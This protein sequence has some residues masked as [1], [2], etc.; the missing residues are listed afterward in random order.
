M[1]TKNKYRVVK[2]EEHYSY[3]S[4]AFGGAT[5]HDTRSIWQ[6]VSDQGVIFTCTNMVHPKWVRDQLNKCDDAQ[7]LVRHY[8]KEVAD[9]THQYRKIKEEIDRLKQD[10]E[11]AELL[12]EVV[13]DLAKRRGKS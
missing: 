3:T 12:L 13:K 7:L 11:H 4:G 2:T 5:F 8:T 10:R 9:I 1:A 6:V